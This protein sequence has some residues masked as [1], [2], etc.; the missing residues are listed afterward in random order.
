MFINSSDSTFHHASNE[1]LIPLSEAS[2]KSGYSLDHLRR[3][4]QKGKMYGRR[5]GRNYVTTDN[6]IEE[7]KAQSPRPGP[8]PIKNK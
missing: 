8:K 2:L 4:I 6:A 7:Y 3:L 1:Q 5:I